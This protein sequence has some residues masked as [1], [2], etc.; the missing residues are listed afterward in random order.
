MSREALPRTLAAVDEGR[1][2]GLHL[3]AQ[4]FV[5]RAGETVANLAVGE[6]RPGIALETDS[7]MLW[8]SSTKPILVL[9]LAQLWEQGKLVLDDPIARVLPEFA[10]G[11]KETI[12][13]RHALTHTGGFR[14]FEVG[15]PEL[16]WDETLA[17]ICAA[18]REPRWEPGKKAGYHN[19]T[20]WFVLGEVVQRL[21]ARPLPD[22]VRA[23]LFEPLDLE[24]AW[25]GM[26]AERY[27][28]YG[29]RIAPV[30]D[31]TTTAMR[32]LPWST[33]LHCTRCSP[34]GGGRG[35]VSALGRIYE[36]LLA[37]GV[38]RGRRLLTPQTIEALVARHRVGMM[39]HTFKHVMDWGLGFIPDSK[40]YGVDVPYAYGRHCSPRTYGHSG[41]RSS[42]AFADPE[43]DLAVAVAFN[44]LPA[45]EVHESRIRRVVEAI[46]E[47]LG[48]V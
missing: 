46:Y 1:E 26:P 27:R 8:M 11:G 7:L 22:L 29:G 43:H 44:G 32:E 34:A 33:E 13:I 16:T 12:T 41:Y 38:W 10:Q 45:D 30:W 28:S 47:D 19:A 31:T 14:M 40:Q 20:S 3:G 24:D 36:M 42:T 48:L 25:V 18:R 37:G 35:P 23:N 39:D 2:R 5:S 6:T 21:S 9:V 17:K 4:L 15:W